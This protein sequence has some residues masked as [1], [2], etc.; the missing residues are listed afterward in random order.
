MA[1]HHNSRGEQ[2]SSVNKRLSTLEREVKEMR[3][4]APPRPEDVVARQAMR[5]EK[6]DFIRVSRGNA[7]YE[8]PVREH[9]QR[10]RGRSSSG[11]AADNERGAASP[12][13]QRR[14]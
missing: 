1:K 12:L 6:P 4:T 7:D 13:E 10:L 11:V 9:M 5:G 2:R 8:T 14:K 3:A